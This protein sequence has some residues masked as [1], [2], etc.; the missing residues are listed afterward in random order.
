MPEAALVAMPGVKDSMPYIRHD[1]T[2]AI[3]P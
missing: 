2:I 1:E 3:I